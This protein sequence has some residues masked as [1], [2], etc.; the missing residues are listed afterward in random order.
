METYRIKVGKLS[1]NNN[2]NVLHDFCVNTTNSNNDVLD[3]YKRNYSGFDV[4]LSTVQTIDLS[5]KKDTE[6][7]EKEISKLTD[8]LENGSKIK[9]LKND[10]YRDSM[11]LEYKNK[12]LELRKISN[13]LRN[14]KEE[15]SDLAKKMLKDKYSPFCENIISLCDDWS[16]PYLSYEIQ[17]RGNIIEK[18][19]D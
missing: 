3:Y 10:F 19:V 18:T 6:Y 1:R 15:L 17:L 4:E 8:K 9:I 11:P 7:L 5:I 16:S 12:Y 2:L 13:D 14:S